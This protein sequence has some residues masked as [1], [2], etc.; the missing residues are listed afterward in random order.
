[1]N[2]ESIK[3][4]LLGFFGA[5]TL[6]SLLFLES[7]KERLKRNHVS[8]AEKRDLAKELLKLIAQFESSPHSVDF[9]KKKI[10]DLYAQTY[11]IKGSTKTVADI[12]SFLVGIELLD[13]FLTHYKSPRQT[14]GYKTLIDEIGET[15]E[16]LK[17][18][19]KKWL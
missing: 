8:W 3:D 5:S 11:I 12:R 7:F 15:I 18:E 1:M 13:L 6:F 4:I 9:E 19:L 17:K 14:K 16:S 10:N 2:F